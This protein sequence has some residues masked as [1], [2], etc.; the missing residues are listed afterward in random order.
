MDEISDYEEVLTSLT[1]LHHSTDA[2]MMGLG[3]MIA[4]MIITLVYLG[5]DYVNRKNNY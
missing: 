5:W 3:L 4:C 2:L 1:K